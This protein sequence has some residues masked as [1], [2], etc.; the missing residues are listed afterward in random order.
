VVGQVERRVLIIEFELVKE[1]SLREE[2]GVCMIDGPWE[3]EIWETEDT[4]RFIFLIFSK[5]GVIRFVMGAKIIIYR[6]R[7]T[8]SVS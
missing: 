2:W 1:H 3:R 7:N 4:F 6:K 8:E 5:T